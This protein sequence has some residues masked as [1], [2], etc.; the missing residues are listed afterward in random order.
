MMLY[1]SL[2]CP[3]LGVHPAW[4]ND[5]RYALTLLSP[6][7]HI[8]CRESLNIELCKAVEAR[9]VFSCCRERREADLI[10]E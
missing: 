3:G 9:I 6:P 2:K 5:L 7:P 1:L 8:M 10:I 4:E